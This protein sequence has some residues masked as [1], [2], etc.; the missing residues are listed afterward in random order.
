[1]PLTPVR[2]MVPA[3]A[4]IRVCEVSVAAVILMVPLLV[5]S[6]VTAALALTVRM[7]LLMTFP[8]RVAGSVAAVA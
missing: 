3:S 6:P 4:L 1:M 7:L 2:V 8:I 5:R